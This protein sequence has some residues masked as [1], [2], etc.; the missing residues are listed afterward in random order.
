[1]PEYPQ[2]LEQ[3][4]K[5]DPRYSPAPFWW[6]SGEKLEI[7][8]LR[9]QMDQLSA[10]GIH[11]VVIINLSPNG[12]LFGC[13]PDDPPFLSEPWWDIFAQVCDYAQSIGMYI[14]FYDQIGFSGASYQAELAVQYPD[15]VAEQLHMV[16][17][18]G[19]GQLITECPLAGTP[20]AAYVVRDDSPET[21]FYLP[22]NSRSVRFHAAAPSRLCFV[23]TLHRGYDVVSSS[24]C[25]R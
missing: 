1:M 17:A 11:N 10:M 23:Y 7:G 24:A 18:E 8:R 21:A 2:F 9:W 6:W 20:I 16:R 14:W 13:D 25:Q 15:S 19:V 5:P 4:T 12:T 3:F 22:V